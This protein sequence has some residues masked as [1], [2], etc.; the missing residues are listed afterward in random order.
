VFCYNIYFGV[1]DDAELVVRLTIN[2]QDAETL[3]LLITLFSVLLTLRVKCQAE[4]GTRQVTPEN[5]LNA[6]ICINT[7]AICYH[8]FQNVSPSRLITEYVKITFFQNYDYFYMYTYMAVK[9]CPSH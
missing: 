3:S 8:S 7:T 4:A 9:L 1:G 2:T 5:T 6:F